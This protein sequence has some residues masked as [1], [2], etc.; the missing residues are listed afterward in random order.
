MTTKEIVEK[1][2]NEFGKS[3]YHNSDAVASCVIGLTGSGVCSCC[4]DE[5]EEKM[6][7]LTRTLL[8]AFGEEVIGS[9]EIVGLPVTQEQET[10]NYAKKERNRLKA[11]QRQKVK[12]IIKSLE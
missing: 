5:L 3:R 8:K 1:M 9:T 12:E 10:R 2:E 11:E 6:M 4:I 7:I